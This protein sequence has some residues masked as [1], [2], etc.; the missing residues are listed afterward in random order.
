M[1]NTPLTDNSAIRIAFKDYERDSYYSSGGAG[2]NASGRVKYLY[3][4][5][6]TLRL[7][8]G[9]EITKESTASTPV[10]DAWGLGDY[11]TGDPYDNLTRDGGHNGRPSS[12]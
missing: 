10:I 4:P 5:S 12:S 7:L 3:K 9:G 8:V 1:V 11:P 6:D 2:N